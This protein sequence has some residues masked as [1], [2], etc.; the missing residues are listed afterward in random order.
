M[1]KV[2]TGY[3]PWLATTEWTQEVEQ[4]MQEQLPD[5]SPVFILKTAIYPQKA[6][7]KSIG[8]NK[9]GGKLG[10]ITDAN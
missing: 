7:N 6:R 9:K 10:Y 8:C 4:C 3:R 5:S 1:A 2:F